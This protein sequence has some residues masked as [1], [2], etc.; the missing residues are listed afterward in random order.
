MMSA[1]AC[2]SGSAPLVVEDAIG[3]DLRRLH[4]HEW[5]FTANLDSLIEGPELRQIRQDVAGARH[6]MR[7]EMNETDAVVQPKASVS[8]S[9][10]KRRVQGGRTETTSL[11]PIRSGRRVSSR[12]LTLG[13]A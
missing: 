11:S 1:G 9:S 8:Q 6:L 3:P 13:G 2:A 10:G 7:P 12:I 4:R 5:R